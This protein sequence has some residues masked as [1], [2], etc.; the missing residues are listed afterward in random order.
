MNEIIQETNK[1]SDLSAIDKALAAAQAR[2][3]MKEG[4]S[5][6]SGTTTTIDDTTKR[7][8]KAARDA[9]RAA[10][11]AQIKAQREERKAARQA[12]KANN[13]TPHMKKIERAASVLPTLDRQTELLFNEATTNLSAYH[14]AALALHLQHFNRVKATE[15]ALNQK[16]EVGQTVRIVAGPQKF[17]G[18]MGTVSLARRIRCFVDVPGFKKP[19]YLFTSDVELVEETSQATGTDG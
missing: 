4:G 1:T 19:I 17:I 10:R 2:K 7:A 9:E 5:M 11:Q 15:R 14:V 18:M 13:Q 12:E 3:A 16:L 6:E 8:A